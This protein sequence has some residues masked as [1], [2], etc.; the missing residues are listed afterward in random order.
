MPENQNAS[1]LYRFN[2]GQRLSL[3]FGVLVILAL[4]IGAIAI[5]T[6]ILE[7][8]ALE[9]TVQAEE[10]VILAEKVQIELFDARRSE[11]DFL[12]NWQTEGFDTAFN[13]YIT[14][15]QNNVTEMRRVL[16]EVI[17]LETSKGDTEDLGELNEALEAIDEYE[18]LLGEVITGLQARGSLTSGLRGT[19]SEQFEAWDEAVEALEIEEIDAAVDELEVLSLVYELNQQ[20][21]VATTFRDNLAALSTTIR[22]QPIPAGQQNN[23]IT[24]AENIQVTFDQLVALD[25][26]N[27][28]RA[29]E[30]EATAAGIVPIIEELIEE[31]QAEA[32]A[33][34]QD[35]RGIE[36]VVQVVEVA[37]LIVVLV[38]GITLASSIRRSI[39]TPLDELATTAASLTAGNLDQRVQNITQDEI[40]AVAGTF[41]NMAQQ[42]QDM[43]AGLEETV[44]ERTQ[45]LATAIEVGGLVTRIASQEEL[46]PQ[47]TDFIRNQFDLYYAQ[48][49]LL[50]EAKRYAVLRAGTGDAGQQLLARGHRLD[51]AETSIVA[52]TVQTGT[53][54]LVSNTETSDVHSPNPL[55]PDTRSEVAIPLIVGN[56]ILGVLDMQAIEAETFN[57]ENLPVF[58]AMA[59]Q[60]ASALQGTAL[61]DEAQTAISRAEAVNRRLAADQW[62]G[63]LGRL[64][65]GQGIGYE[66]DLEAPRPLQASISNG[67]SNGNHMLQTIKL[68]EQPIGSILIG[69]DR[70]REWLPEEV[71]LIQDVSGRLAQALEQYRSYDETQRRAVELQA[72]A[73]VSTEAT[74]NLDI[75]A[76]MQD[77]VDLTKESFNLYHVHIYLLDEQGENLVLAAGAD[78]VGRQLTSQGHSIPLERE[79]SIVAT[80]ARTRHEVRINDVTQNPNH[81]PN[82]LLPDTLAEMAIPMVIGDRVVGVLDVQANVTNRFSE[83]DVQI[84][85]TLAGQVAVAVENA[86]SFN[87]TQRL[88]NELE[89]VA[90]LSTIASASLDIETVLQNVVDL[91]KESFDLYHVHIY[92]LDEQSENLVLAAGAD[93]VGRQMTTQGHR[94]PLNREDSVVATAA[95]TRHETRVND[96]TQDPNHLPNPLLPDTL[97]EMAIPIVIGDRVI[98]VLD[99]QANVTNRFSEIDVQIKST[100]AGQIA[101]AVENARSFNQ[102]QRLANELESVARVSAEATT[103]LDINALMQDVVDLTKESF[104]LYH[105]HIYLLDEFGENLVLAAGAGDVGRQMTNEGHSI[106]LGRE[107]SVVATAARTR[108]ET[109][110]NDVTQD[111]NHLPNPLLPDTLAEMAIPMVVGDHLV[112]VLD[113]QANVTNR[114]GE[115]DVQ[116]KTTLAGQV[117]VA[118]ENARSFEQAREADRLKSEFLANMSHELRTPLNSIIGYSEVIL[119]G[120]DGE[121]TEDMEEDILAIHGSG[122]HLLNIINDILDLAK[123]EA[124]KMV[125]N[126]E[127]VHLVEFAKEITRAGQI[128]VKDKPVTLNL[129]E[130]DEVPPVY[131]DPIRLRQII[132]NLISNAVKFTEEGSVTVS[133]GYESESHAFVEVVDTGI[134][135]KKEELPQIFEQFRQVDGSST[136]RAGGTGLGLNITR[137]LIEMH[138]GA[139]QVESEYGVGTIFRFTVPLATKI[140][141][142]NPVQ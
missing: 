24:T 94:I 140:Q 84:K 74:T 137:H 40:G 16:S 31:A 113:V 110:V 79:D 117:A 28:A 34:Q 18:T 108:R 136:R 89:S 10:E 49:Y 41:N 80:A 97:A 1:F 53:P 13:N 100:L 73:R 139:V 85:S 81:L 58:Q 106:P 38:T 55:L 50:D 128:L 33:S 130:S 5:A 69:E 15:N 82:S 66:Y 60:L 101:V 95:R 132:W 86:R 92:L 90:R 12:L 102:T 19:I 46:L 9:R 126:R 105:V 25:N 116:I 6:T 104:N 7:D 119:D 61:Y 125:I 52:R 142:D 62:E 127:A 14:L 67:E 26:E 2:I 4:I 115:I 65:A 124:G 56:D 48:I 54:V 23:L 98:G 75:N 63:Y 59:N 68:G 43:I 118:V 93:E 11:K 83:I 112:G 57:E 120:V 134:G 22:S 78:E 135:M 109:R 39:I 77:V 141:L 21:S 70:E 45:D 51:L 20:E 122:Q 133:I 72:V 107:D 42:I 29:V 76:L 8:Q 30:F 103:N 44:A 91:T 111:P 3:G 99:V 96:V 87:Q 17:A 88:A 129:V 35:F 114:F 64:G 138:D 36:Q 37:A 123:I 32:A 47:V 121:L 71:A 131:A 27:A